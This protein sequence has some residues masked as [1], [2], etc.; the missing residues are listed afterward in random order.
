MI[1]CHWKRNAPRADLGWDLILA[2]GNQR[3]GG[4]HGSIV[5]VADDPSSAFVCQS[6]LRYPLIVRKTVIACHEI[7]VLVGIV[8]CCQNHRTGLSFQTHEQAGGIR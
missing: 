5:V 2:E 6:V 4:L 1:G 3:A 7:I 8:S